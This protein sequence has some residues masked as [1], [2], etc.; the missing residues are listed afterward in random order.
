MDSSDTSVDEGF[1][2]AGGFT[3]RP[4]NGDDHRDA[5][6]CTWNFGQQLTF[7]GWEEN[8]L[9][10]DFG[11]FL[12]IQHCWIAPGQH[13][14]TPTCGAQCEQ[15]KHSHDCLAWVMSVAAHGTALYHLEGQWIRH[16]PHICYGIQNVDSNTRPLIDLLEIEFYPR[17]IRVLIL[18]D[19]IM[20]SPA[21][22]EEQKIIDQI[23]RHMHL[24]EKFKTTEAGKLIKQNNYSD[25]VCVYEGKFEHA[26]KKQRTENRID[27]ANLRLVFDLVCVSLL[28]DPKFDV[29]PYTSNTIPFEW[30]SEYIPWSMIT[31]YMEPRLFEFHTSSWISAL[32]I[33]CFNNLR[34]YNPWFE[35]NDGEEWTIPSIGNL[36]HYALIEPPKFIFA[37]DLQVH[38]YWRKKRFENQES[39]DIDVLF[40]F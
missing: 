6:V 30:I 9:L 32:H 4:C 22:R 35:W 36:H 8:K 10:V 27:N 12:D 40:Q 29:S 34:K 14:D 19:A 26:R 3:L 28:N 25:I 1:G 20:P 18:E 21:S 39:Q 24:P 31:R 15:R 11:E 33:G 37:V 38:L 23:M 2:Y 7:D 13:H 16:D 17:W 5:N